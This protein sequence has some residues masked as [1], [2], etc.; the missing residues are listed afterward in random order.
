MT[1]STD[2]IMMMALNSFG[3]QFN[4]E[5]IPSYGDWLAKHTFNPFGPE[6]FNPVPDTRPGI[7][8]HF[9]SGDEFWVDESV[10][11]GNRV[12]HGYGSSEDAT[13]IFSQEVRSVPPSVDREFETNG[14]YRRDPASRSRRNE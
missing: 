9:K 8:L 4:P 13:R 12:N 10:D 7:P 11:M 1:F 6:P 14:I 5:S 2:D 3:P